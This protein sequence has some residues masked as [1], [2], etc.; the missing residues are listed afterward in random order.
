MQDVPQMCP[1]NKS[2]TADRAFDLILD[3]YKRQ[4]I[5]YAYDHRGNLLSV[6]SGEGVLRAYGFDAAN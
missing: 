5:D 2:E 4:I 1:A 6:T 3:V